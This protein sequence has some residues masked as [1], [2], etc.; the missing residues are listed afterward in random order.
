MTTQYEVKQTI[1]QV[2]VLAE[3][4]VLGGLNWTEA[5][6]SAKKVLENFVGWH[7][8]H[9]IEPL[10]T[11]GAYEEAITRLTK[12]LD[13]SSERKHIAPPDETL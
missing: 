7:A 4:S 10:K 9:Q 6:V 8:V 1:D 12:V 5:Y 11:S 2:I 3:R 13:K